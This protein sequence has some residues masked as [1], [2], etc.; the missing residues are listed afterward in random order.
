MDSKPNPSPDRILFVD[1]EPLVC[2]A[3]RRVVSPL[4]R[5][6][7]VA[8]TVQKAVALAG[9][10]DYGLVVVDA[11]LR[12]QEG[13]IVSE[14]LHALQ[15]E[16]SFLRM[17]SSEK[18]VPGTGRVSSSRVFTKPWHDDEMLAG[19]RAAFRTRPDR[20]R[21]QLLSQP[22][23]PL[24]VLMVGNRDRSS[25]VARY[26]ASAQKPI[27]LIQV[28]TVGEA[29]DL[30][31]ARS[32]DAVMSDVSGREVRGLQAV[33]QLASVT[34][35]SVPLLILTDAFSQQFA[36]A[37]LDLGAHDCLDTAELSARKLYRALSFAVR[38][39]EPERRLQR[40]TRFDGLTGLANRATFRA[41]VSDAIARHDE[42]G[43]AFAVLLVNLDRFKTLNDSFGP[44]G[45]DMLV[46]ELAQRL[47]VTV[48]ERGTLA[49]RSGDE[50]AILLDNAEQIDPA[51]VASEILESIGQPMT[52]HQ[53]QV[54]MTA[55][56]GIASY[57]DT[58]RTVDGLLQS[59]DTAM[60][61]AKKG[62]RNGV[63]HDLRSHQHSALPKLR[64][65]GDLR[66]A[67]A[68]REFILHYQ[69]QFCMRTGELVAVEAL[70]RWK[71]GDQLVSP[72][73]FVPVLEESG[74]IVPAG[75]W[76]LEEAA[77]T[78]RT[79]MAPGAP[80]L[81]MSVNISA[82]QFT[83]H[84]L[85]DAVESAV[86]KWSVPP[87]ALELEITENLLMQDVEHT[88]QTLEQL[89][90]HGVRIA[91][92]DFGTGYSS[93]SY[94]HRFP[95]DL[96]K[97]DR[98]FVKT[99]DTEEQGGVIASSITAL[100]HKLGMEVIA[101]GVETTEQLRFLI[102]GGCDLVQGFLLGKP[103]PADSVFEL[104]RRCRAEDTAQDAGRPILNLRA[105]AV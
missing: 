38:R 78:L 57:P 25:N 81:R 76:I 18:A 23:E 86:K 55:S 8:H 88:A 77:K 9:A 83:G 33:E 70:L 73:Q 36:D 3:F 34:P 84:G 13:R 53:T 28:E 29:S 80:Q 24:G 27:C 100:G 103:Q 74:L 31:S 59:A 79:W 71:R 32:F 40:L 11:D 95:V 6:V 7:D 26:V 39:K 52:M 35:A 41:S 82:K 22:T 16:A 1:P 47:K 58:S 30:L 92:D 97:I 62:G 56:I 54:F 44:D 10:Q 48:G 72:G 65:E 4:N 68:E 99:I 15:P 5:G 87:G 63:R 14:R 20:A 42:E 90:A 2:A 75:E 46:K 60:S 19:V 93:L 104:I 67:L 69:P 64:M 94:L 96:I 49:R 102:D 37:A 12:D 21:S 51:T 66:H 43:S 101:E 17:V 89:R 91:V 105:E 98:A 85:K 45:A 50:F 61:S